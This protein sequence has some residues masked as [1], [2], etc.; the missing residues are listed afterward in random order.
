MLS[1]FKFN[2]TGGYANVTAPRVMCFIG[3]IG[4]PRFCG[5]RKGNV[6]END[7]LCMPRRNSKVFLVPVRLFEAGLINPSKSLFSNS[8]LFAS[9]KKD[10]DL[11]NYHV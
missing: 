8:F 1:I 2:W 5:L 4:E 10:Y 3:E 11:Y 6:S 7:R 9:K